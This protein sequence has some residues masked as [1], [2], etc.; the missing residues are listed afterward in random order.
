V[1]KLN[2]P[3]LPKNIKSIDLSYFLKNF[4]YLLL[5]FRGA[6]IGMLYLDNVVAR[7]KT[8][9]YALKSFLEGEA[10]IFFGIT[11][12]LGISLLSA[13]KQIST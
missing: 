9:H 5:V 10:N 11:L 1:F 6:G 13:S 12:G 7:P 8:I 4:C 2:F 3:L